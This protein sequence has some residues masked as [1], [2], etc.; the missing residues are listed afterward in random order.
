MPSQILELEFIKKFL[1]I[2]EDLKNRFRML[3]P[4]SSALGKPFDQYLVDFTEVRALGKGNMGEV[5]LVKD[6]N[7]NHFAAKKQ[8]K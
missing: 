5:W 1:R 7:K 3:A 2:E 4:D 6:K 8:L